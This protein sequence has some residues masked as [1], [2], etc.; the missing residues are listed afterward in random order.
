MCSENPVQGCVL[1]VLDV[2]G[3]QTRTK[4]KPLLMQAVLQVGRC[5]WCA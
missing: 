3:G 2:L 1:N 5:S 4:Q